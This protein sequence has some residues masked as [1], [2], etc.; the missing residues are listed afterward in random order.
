MP[1]IDELSQEA[2]AVTRY[3]LRLAL[4]VFLTGLAGG[5]GAVLFNRSD[6]PVIF[7]CATVLA[8]L[9][10]LFAVGLALF[11]VVQIRL[12][13]LMLVI[14][15]LGNVWGFSY[16]TLSDSVAM[17]VGGRAPM[18]LIIALPCMV[19]ALGGA[20]W[21]LWVAKE[22]LIENSRSRLWLICVGLVAPPAFLFAVA[23]IP[24]TAMAFSQ[25]DPAISGAMV[26]GF[27]VCFGILMYA[28]KIHVRVMKE[29]EDSGD[30]TRL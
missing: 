18:L 21:G 27:F 2:G 4:I 14:A 8:L 17:S 19:W 6:G 7:V 22:L 10:A 26:L 28:V 30:E 16:K 3:T 29:I 24:L 13:E 5:T 20:T 25:L 11:R 9:M 1:F 23:A 15:A 12:T